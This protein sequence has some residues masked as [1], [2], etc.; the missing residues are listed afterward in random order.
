MPNA[1]YIIF[2]FDVDPADPNAAAITGSVQAALPPVPGIGS[3]GVEGVFLVEVPPSQAD[4][5]FAQIAHALWS[6]DQANGLAL[7]WFA[8]LCGTAEFAGG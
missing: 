2:A 5:V 4:N 3:L 1:P 6:V 8:Q 7:R